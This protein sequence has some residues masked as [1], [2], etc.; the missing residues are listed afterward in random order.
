MAEGQTRTGLLT[1]SL[2]EALAEIPDGE[3][4]TAPW[5]RFWNRVRARIETDPDSPVQHSW[6][7]GG[8]ARGM[9]GRPAERR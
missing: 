2:L 8:L 4:A 3:L 9:A 5:G 1:R 6:M 7:S